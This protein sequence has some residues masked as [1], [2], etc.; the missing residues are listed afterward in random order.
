MNKNTSHTEP[1][2]RDNLDA[3]I[4]KFLDGETDRAQEI[5][6][7]QFF[8]SNNS[9]PERYNRLR[10]MFGWYADG[11]DYSKLPATVPPVAK[12]RNTIFGRIL[13]WG[14]SVAAAAVIVIMVGIG[15]NTSAIAASTQPG[16]YNHIVRDGRLITGTDE[17]IG[18]IEATLLAG[19]L[20][21]AEI[22]SDISMLDDITE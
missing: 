13:I 6:L 20:L 17:I 21:D 4:Q 1:I 2:T 12:K 18:D 19:R 10:D 3:M 5:A 14:S 7:E 22:D 8:M 9:L 15:N 16:Q 11:M